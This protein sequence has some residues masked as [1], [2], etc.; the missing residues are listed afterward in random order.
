[1]ILADL[2]DSTAG[3]L[4]LPYFRARVADAERTLASPCDCWPDMH[5]G[6]CRCWWSQ[7]CDVEDAW[8]DLA[9]AERQAL[10]E[11]ADGRR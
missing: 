6:E 7:W 4:G 2:Q 5:G 10:A 11:L 3:A 9:A 1:M 8:T